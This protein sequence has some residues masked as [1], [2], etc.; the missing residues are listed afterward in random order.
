MDRVPLPRWRPLLLLKAAEG[1][2]GDD[3]GSVAN[4]SFSFASFGS[5]SPVFCAFLP[6]CG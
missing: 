1:E 5:H 3:S 6:F 2:N 4:P